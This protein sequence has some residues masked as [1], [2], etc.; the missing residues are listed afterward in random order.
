MP[1]K[2]KSGA[3]DPMGSVLMSLR[4]STNE[5]KPAMKKKQMANNKKRLFHFL[6]KIYR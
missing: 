2:L 3:L 5:G 4:A 1:G 6:K